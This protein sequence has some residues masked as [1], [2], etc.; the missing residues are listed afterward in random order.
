MGLPAQQAA[1]SQPCRGS[2]L[3]RTLP[4]P[5]GAPPEHLHTRHIVLLGTWASSHESSR[6]KSPTI[7][8]YVQSTFPCGI[9][10]G[11]VSQSTTNSTLAAYDCQVFAGMPA[12]SSRQLVLGCS[13]ISSWSFGQSWSYE[14]RRRTLLHRGFWV[15][16]KA[17]L[18]HLHGRWCWA[19]QRPLLVTWVR[20][21]PP[22]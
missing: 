16:L 3:Q 2:P 4:T 22:Q 10:P 19:A 6:P 18:L 8:R 1:P 12:A 9:V 5:S 13:E 17:L 21:A 11:T 14:D 7:C 20:S 15:H